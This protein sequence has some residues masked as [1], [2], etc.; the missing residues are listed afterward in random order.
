MGG[1]LTITEASSQRARPTTSAQSD[2]K[3]Q[4]TRDL[5]KT[6][7]LAGVTL[8]AGCVALFIWAIAAAP[9]IPKILNLLGLGTLLLGGATL[10]GGVFGL[11]FGIP[12]SISDPASAA[13]A[14]TRDNDEKQP[15]DNG[16]GSSYAVNTNLEQISDWLTKIIVGV[17][18]T[19]IPTIRQEFHSLADFF[20]AGFAICNNAPCN[21]GSTGA[22]LIITY[23]LMTGFLAGYLLT[24]MFLPGAFGRADREAQL[25]KRI[26]EQQEAV[27]ALGRVQGEIYEQL[28]WYEKEGFRGAITTLDG[29]LK[30]EA[31]KKNPALW[32]YLAAAH[33]QAYQWAHDHKPSSDKKDDMQ[34]WQQELDY[35]RNEALAAVKRALALGDS[36]KPILQVMWDRQHPLKNAGHARDES[37]LEPFYDDPEFRALLGN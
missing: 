29:L 28:Y 15:G 3:D 12:K 20:G 21:G 8:L 37:D 35:H 10:V 30:S 31:N 1:E 32:V 27:Q 33:G 24:R 6:A 16:R 23:G 26:S 22:A 14:R 4:V 2:D 11:L 7:R 34:K 17:S 5:L 19:Q 18:L 25:L 36:W 9:D 13:P